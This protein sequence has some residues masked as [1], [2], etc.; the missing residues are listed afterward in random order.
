[1]A[2]RQR[3]GGGTPLL[4]PVTI[5]RLLV[6]IVSLLVWELLSRWLGSD[7]LPGPDET[8]AMIQRGVEAGWIVANLQNTMITLALGFAIAVVLGLVLGM[9]L[10]FGETAFDVFEIYVLSSYSVPKIIL[11][12][13]F[14]FVFQLGMDTKIA[15]GAVHGFFPM[16]IIT[17][18]A[19]REIDDIYKKVALSLDLSRWQLFRHVV[20]P[21]ILVQLVVALR[22]AFSL[23]FLGV[24]LAELFA[25]KS[26]LGL[27]LQHAMA[28]FQTGRIMAVVTILMVIA[29][30]GNLAFYAAQRAL[31]NRWNMDADTGGV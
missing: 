8:L 12:P 13:I 22:L 3:F 7:L 27:I 24:I 9:A 29:I 16:L 6:P 25:S 10:G 23:T 26:G 1:M 31:E 15:F 28:N 5:G 4:E 2:T 14:L 30:A 19:I 21:F 18:G 17:M 11:Y 20:F